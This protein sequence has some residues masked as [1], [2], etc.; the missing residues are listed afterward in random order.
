[1][2]FE[3]SYA[4]QFLETCNADGIAPLW[5]VKQIFEEH[6]IDLPG[7]QACHGADAQC[8]QTILNYLGY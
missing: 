3:T 7:F 1:M 8:G 6:G 4:G 2:D 5:A